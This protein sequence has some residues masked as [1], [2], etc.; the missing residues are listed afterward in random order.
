MENS[1]KELLQYESAIRRFFE[2]RNC[3]EDSHDL[4]QETMM[5]AFRG[6]P[7]WRGEASLKTWVFCIAKNTW[8]KHNRGEQNRRKQG[9]HIVEEV[10]IDHP[11]FVEGEAFQAQNKSPHQHLV[12]DQT[13]R[14]LARAV[15]EL[16]PKMRQVLILR[17]TRGMK[18]SDIA[19][20]LRIQENTVKSNLN[21]ARTRLKPILEKYFGDSTF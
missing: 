1:I 5:K 12:Q 16:P 13:L 19:K 20:L 15:D 9:D 17:V 7:N 14:A 21:H 6:L 2:K 3:G 18:Y 8:I 4:T 11:D 10:S